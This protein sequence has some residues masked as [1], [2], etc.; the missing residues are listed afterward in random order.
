MQTFPWLKESL[1]DIKAPYSFEKSP[2]T[3]KGWA[4]LPNPF[5]CAPSMGALLRVEVPP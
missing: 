3:K 1:P 5:S 4:K 2:D